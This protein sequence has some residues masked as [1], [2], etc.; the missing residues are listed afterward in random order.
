MQRF[1]IRFI[2]A[3]LTFMIGAMMVSVWMLHRRSATTNSPGVQST[4]SCS[5]SPAPKSTAA[6]RKPDHRLRLLTTGEFHGDDVKAKTGEQWLGLYPGGN[7]FALLASRLKINF[8]HDDLV[9]EKPKAKTG[10]RVGV[11]RR[12]D[13]IFLIKGAN[14]PHSGTVVTVYKEE[15]SL[16]NG[17]A[18]DL[19]LN[20]TNYRLTVVS[21]NEQ[22]TDYGVGADSKLMLTDGTTTQ[23]LFVPSDS[24]M[25]ADEPFIFLNWAGDL[26]GDGK[27]DLYMTLSPHYNVRR[28]VLLLS[29]QADEGQLVEEVAEFIA[30]GC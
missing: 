12:P 19:K 8:V 6:T 13:P 10:K 2:A 16:G 5:S 3:S 22:P 4:P 28:Q 9:D 15:K 14:L 23:V 17:A 7:S 11:D 27:L 30:T 29:S 18:V 1:T 21:N 24:E 26:D 25:D 20:G